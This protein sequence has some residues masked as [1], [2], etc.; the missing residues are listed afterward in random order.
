MVRHL[1]TRLYG[2]SWLLALWLLLTAVLVLEWEPSGARLEVGTVSPQDIRTPE[3]VTYR[4]EVRTLRELERV[5]SAV[6]PIYF[7][8]DRSQAIRQSSIALAIATYLDAVRADPYADAESKAA[9]IAALQPVHFDTEITQLILALSEEQWRVVVSETQRVVD[10]QMRGEIKEADLPIVL[11]NLPNQLSVSL[12]KEQEQVVTAWA[13]GLV[14]PNTFLDSERTE[15]ARTTAREAVASTEIT[16][17]KG[18]IIVREGDI[19]TPEQVE[20]LHTL[21]L[22]Q[23]ARPIGKILSTTV[24][25][26]FMV[27]VLALYIN[28][29]YPEHWDNPRTMGLILML[30][31]GFALGARLL[32]PDHKFMT[33][34]LPTSTAAMLLGVLLG[35]DIAIVV[36]IVLSLIVG[37]ITDSIEMISYTFISGI[38]A[39][40]VLWR[41]E[42]LGVFVWTG[43]LVGLTN[44]GIMLAFALQDVPYNWMD[45]AAK[46]GMALLNGALSASLALIGFYVLSNFLGITTFLQLLELAH[47]NHP[48]FRE[49]QMK[50]PGTYHH[51]IIVSNL[52]ERAAE[53]IGADMLLVRVG[54]YYHDVGKSL[55]PHYF[56]ENQ[57]DGVNFH[58]ALDDPYESAE[59]IL[60]HVSEGLRLAHR[61]KLPRRIR[62][63]IAQHHGTTCV[64]WFYH[65]ACEQSGETKI[66]S[67]PF[68]YPGPKPQSRETAILMLADTV[69]ATSRA[70][71]PA[72]AVEVDELIRKIIVTKLGDGQLDECSL[73]LRDLDKI[74]QAFLDV[75]QGIYHPRLVYPEERKEN[76]SLVAPV[77]AALTSEA[78]APQP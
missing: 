45:I 28:R 69:E 46:G 34:L 16:L 65:K 30:L 31:V 62:D 6:R 64:T 9:Y 26:L 15:Q 73:S 74:R 1:V 71:K 33:Y 10:V 75:L 37:F 76:R 72:G 43:L 47:P 70:I 44:M 32:M 40:L 58:D 55:N 24:F 49:L 41:V 53:T 25:L 17:A 12:T 68:R 5:A 14:L 66:D 52:A 54:A 78:P 7:P 38:I 39:A 13:G 60:G 51:T 61:H 27:L 22:Q 42:R 77:P 67:A 36:T 59:I 20:A 11:R 4:S 56:I 2:G 50:A 35:V 19:I 18:Q 57:T 21:G 8:P 63:F 48:L 3:R 23:P 29:V